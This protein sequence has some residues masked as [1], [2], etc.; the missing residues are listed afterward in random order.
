MFNRGR[1]VVENDFK[2]EMQVFISELF[3]EANENRFEVRIGET[4]NAK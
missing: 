2:P 4:T 1:F 3:R